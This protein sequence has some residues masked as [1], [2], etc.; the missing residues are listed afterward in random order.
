MLRLGVWFGFE[1]VGSIDYFKS[2]SDMFGFCIFKN[3][4][5]NSDL[6]RDKEVCYFVVVIEGEK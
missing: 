5:G 3:F 1:G 6:G 2:G 4:F